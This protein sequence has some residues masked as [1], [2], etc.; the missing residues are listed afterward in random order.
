M[1]E[2]N[3]A[4]EVPEVSFES[5]VRE[6]KKGIEARRTLIAAEE[7]RLEYACDSRCPSCWFCWPNVWKNAELSDLLSLFGQVVGSVGMLFLCVGTG[8][9]KNNVSAEECAKVQGYWGTSG[10]PNASYAYA[11]GKLEDAI[12]A[13]CSEVVLPE[14]IISRS[15]FEQIGFGLL[16]VGG[17]LH[18]T[19]KVMKNK[20]WCGS[21]ASGS[22]SVTGGNGQVA[23]NSAAMAAAG[24]QGDAVAVDKSLAAILGDGGVQ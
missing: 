23:G 6:Q 21:K 11:C 9:W 14:T 24:V 20:G 19:G 22:T 7:Q 15:L 16:F 18:L 5:Q 3:G 10:C 13:S 17:T 2:A 12:N 8:T 4:K 1:S